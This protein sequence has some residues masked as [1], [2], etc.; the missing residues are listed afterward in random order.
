MTPLPPPINAVVSLYQFEAQFRVPQEYYK[1]S[2]FIQSNID[3]QNVITRSRPPLQ[4]KQ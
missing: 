4:L 3:L 2:L 1:K